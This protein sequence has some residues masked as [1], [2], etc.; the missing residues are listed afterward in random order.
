MDSKRVGLLFSIILLFACI[1]NMIVTCQIL[2]DRIAV[3]F[4]LDNNPTSWQHKSGFIKLYLG[5]LLGLNTL[6]LGIL[7]NFLSKIPIHS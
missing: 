6:L 2:P 1:L 5:I 4:D 3:Q 7:P